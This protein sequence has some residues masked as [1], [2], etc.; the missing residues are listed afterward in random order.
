MSTARYALA[1][2]ASYS[3]L[4]PEPAVEGKAAPAPAGN[5]EAKGR[6]AALEPER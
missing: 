6:D 3:L 5:D 4:E 1:V 2:T